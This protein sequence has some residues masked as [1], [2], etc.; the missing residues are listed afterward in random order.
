VDDEFTKRHEWA[1]EVCQQAMVEVQ[2]RAH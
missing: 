2:R 1:N